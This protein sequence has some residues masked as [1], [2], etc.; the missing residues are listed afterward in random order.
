MTALDSLG[1]ESEK[2]TPSEITYDQGP[3]VITVTNISPGGF[4]N[5][6]VIPEIVI[7]DLSETA[8]V[9]MLDGADY[10]GT[11]AITG[12]GEHVLYI[13]ATDLGGYKGTLT[14]NF[15]IDKTPPSLDI[16]AVDEGSFY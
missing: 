16:T 7:S 12:E 10:D 8:K 3:P 4:Y 6:D 15:T 5:T 13:E 1:N 2:S 9:Y 11:S 14:V